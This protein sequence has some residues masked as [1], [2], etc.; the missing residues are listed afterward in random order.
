VLAAIGN[1]SVNEGQALAFTISASNA[2]GGT[3]S[4]S[5]SPSPA[6]AVLDSVSGAF[7]WTPGYTQ[8]GSY[9]VTFTAQVN[10]QTDSETITIAV[11]NV[12]RAPVLIDPGNQLANE[13][14]LLTFALSALDQ[15]V[16]LLL[17]Q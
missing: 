13:T 14:G 9:N 5:M 15:D 11:A 17:I 7:S 12:D 6:G 10:S 3:M 2:G 16:M 1:K 4:Y 8:S